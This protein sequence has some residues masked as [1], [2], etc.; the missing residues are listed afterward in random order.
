[1]TARTSK[2][3]IV[4]KRNISTIN[5]TYDI[6]GNIQLDGYST[7][8][9]QVTDKRLHFLFIIA[10]MILNK[11]IVIYCIVLYCMVLNYIIL[12]CIVL[13]GIELYCIVLYGNELNCIVLYVWIV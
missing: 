4:T 1:M 10:I 7:T 3:Y 8:T 5:T 12:Y 9:S 11:S 2:N 6:R 13:Y